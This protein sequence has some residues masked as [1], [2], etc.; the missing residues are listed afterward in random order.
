VFAHEPTWLGL[1]RVTVLLG[2]IFWMYG[3]YAWLT[4]AVALDRV[5]RRL[6]LLAAMAALLVVALAVPGAFAGSGATFGMAY[7]AVVL[8]HMGLFARSSQ[9]TVVQAMRGLAPFNLFTALL[10]LAGGILG[11]T[12]ETVLWTVAFALEWISPR[13]TDDSGF[14]IAAAH[15]VE[16]HGLVVIVAIGE[17]VVAVGIGAADLPV[18]GALVAGAVLGLALTAALW[19]S[20]FGGDEDAAE[21]ALEAAP[22]QRR[23]RLALEAFGYCHGP[24]LLGVVLIAA[25]LKHATGHPFDALDRPWALALGGGAA[26]FLGGEA[27]LRRTLA[28]G[29]DRE[30][31]LAAVVA[32]LTIPIGT[33]LASAGQVVALLAIFV[34][35]LV[36]AA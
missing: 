4:N 14:V 3:G 23:P 15:F 35:M 19:W 36:A 21:R 29:G 20:Y 5:G 1:F 24:I 12:A 2:L 27:L 28:I 7:L 31:A 6:W 11:G 30:R 17:S 8:I 32:L 16:R 10:V 33:A 9:L 34:A 13:L 25:A 26:V 22:A 18:D